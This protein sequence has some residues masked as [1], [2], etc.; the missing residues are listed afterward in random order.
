MANT[1][2]Y[3]EDVTGAII[4]VYADPS[5][6]QI[7]INSRVPGENYDRNVIVMPLESARVVIEN[8][9]KAIEIVEN[10]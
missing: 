3:K 9:R 5:N 7:T 10:G 4:Q 8:I 6:K 2:F 1:V